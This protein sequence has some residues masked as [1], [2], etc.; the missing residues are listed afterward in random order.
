MSSARP[1]KRCISIDNCSLFALQSLDRYQIIVGHDRS[2]PSDGWGLTCRPISCP[3]GRRGSHGVNQVAS[4]LSA[5]AFDSMHLHREYSIYIHTLNI[6][7]REHTLRE[8]FLSLVSFSSLFIHIN[9]CRLF[10]VFFLFFA[11]YCNMMII[12]CL[13]WTCL[14]RYLSLSLDGCRAYS[15]FLVNWCILSFCLFSTSGSMRNHCC[16]LFLYDWPSI[17]RSSSASTVIVKRSLSL[18]LDRTRV[19][20]H[21]F[22]A[23]DIRLLPR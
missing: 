10:S 19:E 7:Q 15:R 9:Q 11:I 21:F 16:A 1:R 22:V 8:V 12:R 18:D 5:F 17:Y 20:K 6:S 14:S 13:L 2:G 4:T 23:S 3:A